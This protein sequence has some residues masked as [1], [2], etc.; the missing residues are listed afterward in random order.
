M[1]MFSRL[2]T[3]AKRVAAGGPKPSFAVM[4]IKRQS[5][6]SMR[7]HTAHEQR[8]A[9]DLSHINKSK[10]VDNQ[11]VAYGGHTDSPKDAVEAYIKDN[12]IKIDARNTT[13]VTSFVLSASHDWF[14]GPDGKPDPNKISA[15]T[16]V[17]MKWA[18]SEFG[19]DLVHASLHLDEKTPHIHI[20][21]VPT[22]QKKTK[23]QTVRQASHHKNKSFKGFR[24]Y[25]HLLDRYTDALAPLGIER[26]Q[27]VPDDAK[28]TQRT[29]RQWVNDMARKFADMPM[30]TALLDEKEKALVKRERN[31]SQE[32]IELDGYRDALMKAATHLEHEERTAG[33]YASRTTTELARGRADG[34]PLTAPSPIREAPVASPVAPV[35]TEKRARRKKKVVAER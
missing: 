8:T 6:A 4:D 10:T 13:P 11:R 19:E 21:T 31:L 35:R 28:G 1:S 27:K 25:E 33:R 7:G 17:S 20:K 3:M 18:V 14:N 26:G 34:K 29:A 30:R 32:R 22:Y 23:F 5:L 9:G 2:I 24:S 15:F 12:K 16:G